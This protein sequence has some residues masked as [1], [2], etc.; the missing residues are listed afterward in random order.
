[1]GLRERPRLVLG[2]SIAALGTA[3]R[4]LPLLATQHHKII[5]DVFSAVRLGNSVGS[6]PVQEPAADS[7]EPNLHSLGWDELSG[8]ASGLPKN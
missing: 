8:R 2:L 1:M 6:T 4:G 5:T 7:T 3:G